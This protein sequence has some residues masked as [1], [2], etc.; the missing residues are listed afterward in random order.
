MIC[1]VYS[2][3][4]IK[5]SQSRSVPDL[6]LYNLAHAGGWEPCSMHDLLLHTFPGLDLYYADPAQPLTHDLLI[7]DLQVDHDLCGL[8]VV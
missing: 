4:M 1:M 5:I 6:Y 8:S 2:L 7:Y 3:L